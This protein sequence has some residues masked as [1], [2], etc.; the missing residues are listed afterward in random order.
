MEQ[1]CNVDKLT[2]G[3]IYVS[4]YFCVGFKSSVGNV[5]RERTGP[6]IY[7]SNGKVK[8]HVVLMS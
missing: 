2:R 5:V 6:T 3:I 1:P 4:A 8:S 7:S